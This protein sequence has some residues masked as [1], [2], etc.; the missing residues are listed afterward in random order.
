[1]ASCRVSRIRRFDQ[2]QM[3][4]AEEECPFIASDITMS[5][6]KDSI[7]FG[8]YDR[9]YKKCIGV[10]ELVIHLRMVVIRHL[11]VSSK[12][13][14]KKIA[15]RLVDHAVDLAQ[16]LGVRAYAY[17]MNGSEKFWL[18]TKQRLRHR[19]KLDGIKHK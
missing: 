1:M 8:V 4:L 15:T 16:G 18:H 9:T 14:H 19:L 2:L 11:Y 17:A 5:W 12:Y 7:Y 6:P 10:L 13:R 3:L